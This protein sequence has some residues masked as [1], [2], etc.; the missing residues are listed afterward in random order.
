MLF[1]P[2]ILLASA[3]G[4]FGWYWLS[5]EKNKTRHTESTSESLHRDYFRGLNYLI[6]EQP[7]KAVDV[8]IRLLE[9]D[10]D[11]VEMHLA[12]GNLFRQRGEV[13]RAIRIHQNLIAR[14]QLKKR[15]RTQALAALGEDYLKAG[16]LD[17]AE[18]LFLELV[19]LGD[20]D[21]QGLHF[22][23]VIYQR[24]KEWSKAIDVTRKLAANGSSGM[25]VMIAQFFCE[26]ADT[27]SANDEIKQAQYYLKQAE[28]ANDC[29]V[30]VSLL[31]GA[32]AES[33]GR[34]K[35]ALASYV[36]VKKQNIVYMSEVVVP[37]VRCFERL[38]DDHLLKQFLMQSLE[39]CPSDSVI[40]AI[41]HFL[42]RTENSQ[43]AIAF[44]TEQIKH[45]PSLRG[46]EHL[47]KL[48]V[49]N[50]QG[51]TKEKLTILEN[52]IKAYIEDAPLYQCVQCGFSSRVLN[53]QCPSC[54]RWETVRPFSGVKL[55]L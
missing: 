52:L 46:L 40:F 3:A 45:T 28:K 38:G 34:Y 16:V 5:Q 19:K 14:P 49:L 43:V 50:S 32:L 48:Y 36:R 17:R 23:L 4:S 20:K 2:A 9:V 15:H 21:N 31:K 25:S 42:Q 55:T 11:T 41:S 39:A 35:E 51:D 29:C 12:L 7:D 1:I 13:D 22:L 6:N 24:E 47:V 37:I 33:T 18:K 27:A 8:F 53:W 44:L 10:S 30:R 54:H 26:L